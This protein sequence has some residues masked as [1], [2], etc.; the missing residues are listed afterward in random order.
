MNLVPNSYLNYIVNTIYNFICRAT[1]CLSLTRFSNNSSWALKTKESKS[2]LL[3]TGKSGNVAISR[4]IIIL[5]SVRG[6]SSPRGL[7]VFS[8]VSLSLLDFPL[9][10]RAAME[11]ALA[12]DES[13]GFGDAVYSIS[14]G[15]PHQKYSTEDKRASRNP[16]EAPPDVPPAGSSCAP[17]LRRNLGQVGSDACRSGPTPEAVACPAGWGLKSGCSSGSSGP[18]LIIP[19]SLQSGPRPPR[20]GP[21]VPAGLW[22]QTANERSAQLSHARGCACVRSGVCDFMQSWPE[23]HFQIYSS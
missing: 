9:D 18:A 14:V 1:K 23:P 16:P 7:M 4:L 20:H 17:S 19:A 22:Y 11:N 6:R 13:C 3:C 2:H 10:I 12:R 21:T 5:R 8:S 15:A